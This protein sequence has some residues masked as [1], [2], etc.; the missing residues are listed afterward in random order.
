MKAENG[1]PPKAHKYLVHEHAYTHP[2][3]LTVK[4]I[5]LLSCP[6]KIVTFM[7]CFPLTCV[8]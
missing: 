7:K 6:N 1:L 3:S 4:T 8:P 2:L 5:T